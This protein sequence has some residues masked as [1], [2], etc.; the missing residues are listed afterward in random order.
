MRLENRFTPRSDEE[1]QKLTVGE[2]KPHNAPITL[3]EYDPR[4]PEL[5]EREAK[6]IVPYSAAKH[7]KSNMLAQLRCQDFVP[8]QSLI[9]CWL[10]RILQTSHHMFR[11]WKQLAIDCEFENLNGSS[12]VYLKD[13]ILTLTYM[14]SARERLKSIKCYDFEIGCART[15]ATVTNMRK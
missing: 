1:L 7:C 14:C 11:H 13:R 5:F 10:W 3:V 6:R 12:I 9:C 15:R 2:L 4:W 8:S